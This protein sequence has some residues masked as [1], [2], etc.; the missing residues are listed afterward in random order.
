LDTVI[1]Q[2]I[3]PYAC[4][5]GQL[6]RALEI[7]RCLRNFL[8]KS[9]F[10]YWVK[11]IGGVL[12]LLSI[13]LICQSTV[14]NTFLSTMVRIQPERKQHVVST[15]VYRFVRHPYYLGMLLM[16]LGAPFLMGSV[17]GLGIGLIALGVLINR[18]LGEEKMLVNKLEGYAAYMYKV[19][20]R[21]IPRIW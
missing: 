21:L 13:Y 14:E 7:R 10:P 1:V 19:K 15:G 5:D 11:V 12:L 18:I 20:S 17:F 4:S 8:V 6:Y 16:F 3:L 9:D 2:G